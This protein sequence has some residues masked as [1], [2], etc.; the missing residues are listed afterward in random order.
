MSSSESEEKKRKR[1]S[2]LNHVPLSIEMIKEGL[3]QLVT[4]NGRPFSVI[5]DSGLRM[6]LDSIISSLPKEDKVT[7][8]PE[9]VKYLLKEK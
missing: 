6:I 3:L 8:N 9:F 4:I 5:N 1:M 7:I 2:L